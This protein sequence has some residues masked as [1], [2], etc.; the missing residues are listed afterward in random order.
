MI[1]SVCVTPVTHVLMVDVSPAQPYRTYMY[2]YI[3]TN[4]RYIPCIYLSLHQLLKSHHKDQEKLAHHAFVEGSLEQVQVVD[5]ALQVLGR[6]QDAS[7]HEL[8]A[9]L[10]EITALRLRAQ[11]SHGVLQ[12]Q[13]LNNT[14]SV[15][16][17]C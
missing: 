2:K 13:P 5:G 14:S 9:K 7:V 15:D 4:T 12:T 10:A 6:L 3:D 1:M 17:L 11:V 16:D 8:R